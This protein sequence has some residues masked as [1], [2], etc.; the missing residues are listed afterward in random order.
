MCKKEERITPPAYRSGYRFRNIDI[1]ISQGVWL[2]ISGIIF[3]RVSELSVEKG[4]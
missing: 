4:F 1:E 2:N 3:A